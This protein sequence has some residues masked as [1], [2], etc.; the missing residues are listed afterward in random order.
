MKRSILAAVCAGLMTG[1]CTNMSQT[2]QGAVSGAAIGA[3]AGAGIAKIA[4][5]SGWT[6][7][8]VGAAAG[9]VTGYFIGEKKEQTAKQPAPSK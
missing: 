5:G 3:A 1:G 7:A 8:A 6:G 9:G 2:Q 4:G